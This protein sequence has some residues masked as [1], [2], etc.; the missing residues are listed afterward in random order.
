[1]SRVSGAVHGQS[2]GGGMIESVLVLN[3]V[4]AAAASG[5]DGAC[6]AWG[7]AEA[8]GTL[9]RPD[10]IEASG[11]AASAGTEDLYWTMNDSGGAAVI[12]AIDGAG[13]DLGTVAVR[14]AENTDWEDLALGPCSDGCACLTLAD[15]GGDGAT[16]KT[17]M[18]YRVPEPDPGDSR[19]ETAEL[20]SFTWPEATDAE[21]VVVDPQTGQTLFIPKIDAD[22]V[23]V[24]GLPG[25][26][27]EGEDLVAEAVAT[28]DLSD[29]QDQQ[30]TGAAVSPGGLRVAVRTDADLL[31]YTVPEGGTLVDAFDDAPAILPVP[32]T[33]NGEA[34]TFSR[35]GRDVILMG[36]GAGATIWRVPCASPQDEVTVD[37]LEV[38][39]RSCGCATPG[40]RRASWI[41][42]VALWALGRA[43]RDG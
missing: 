22:E 9:E 31:V 8:E 42:V 33:P 39:A 23:T 5:G 1:M 25:T 7:P 27:P 41:V 29:A 40:P 30:V 21:A 10:L 43:R 19:T 32:I 13:A 24:Y 34:L 38:C 18:L 16:R 12:Y 26:P 28:L 15:I 6:A 4:L 2:F 20:I 37:A 17:G 36:E 35:D 11:L 14:G 3:T